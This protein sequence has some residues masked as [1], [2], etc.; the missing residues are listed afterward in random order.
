M[1]RHPEKWWGKYKIP[2]KETL[3]DIQLRPRIVALELW[4][5]LFIIKLDVI[6]N[7]IFNVIIYCLY[8]YYWN[9]G[10][11]PSDI[12]LYKSFLEV[13]CYFAVFEVLE[14]STS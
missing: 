10:T 13:I 8:G 5:G 6:Q 1:D 2:T 4:I 12:P 3:S 14:S 9:R 7:H 11:D